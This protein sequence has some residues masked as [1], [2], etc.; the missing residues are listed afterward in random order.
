METRE[1]ACRNPHNGVV[2]DVP[3]ASLSNA[4]RM[5]AL[6]PGSLVMTR[7]VTDWVVNDPEKGWPGY[8][9]NCKAPLSPP[10]RRDCPNCQADDFED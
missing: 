6:V 8:C 2:L 1:Y 9:Q 4:E 10:D 3:D 5:A 7:T